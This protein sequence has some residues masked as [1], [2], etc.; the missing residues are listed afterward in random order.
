VNAKD[1]PNMSRMIQND[2]LW[3]HLKDFDKIVTFSEEKLP[4]S[5]AM[6]D[7]AKVARLLHAFFFEHFHATSVFR[8]KTREIARGIFD[9]ETQ[10]NIVVVFNLARAFMEHT[11]SLA[12][13]DQALKKAV[14]DISNKQVF[15]QIE[16][17]ISRHRQI[18]ER[19]YYGG[20]GNPKSAKRIHV[21]DL[22][23][24]L[25]DIYHEAG[26]DYAKLCEFVHPNYGSNLLVSSGT[27]ASGAIGVPSDL[28][29]SELSFAHDVVERCAELDVK[30]IMRNAAYLANVQN[31]IEAASQKGAKLT[32]IFSTR[33]A[34][35]GDG[36]SK[37]TAIFFKKARTHLE[38]MQAFYKFLSEQ[39]C[40]MHRRQQAAIEDGFLFDIVLTDK[41]P[42]WVKYRIS[43][44]SG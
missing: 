15:S 10:R 36:K 41:G 21:N 28:M 22:L 23:A 39:G 16:S 34:H 9:A 35:E 32:Q 7:S 29:S 44:L 12:F 18:A 31:W 20:E 25:V 43:L 26:S 5:D 8:Y 27:L 37:E 11:A 13:Q 33:E 4:P 30:I 24:A 1:Y 40:T 38:A 6:T 17:C 3:A 19:L 2:E 42:L 14:D